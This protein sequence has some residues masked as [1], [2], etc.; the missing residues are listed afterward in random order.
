MLIETQT[1]AL[2]LLAVF[3]LFLS[4]GPNMAFVLSH[5][6]AHGARGGFAAALGITAADLVLTLLTVTGFTATV[7]AWPPAFDV[8]RYAG[9]LYLLVL[10][11]RAMRVPGSVQLTQR[12][13][14]SMGRI[15]CTAMLN[16][17]LNPKALLFFL[18]F[19]PQFVNPS[20]G[21]IGMQ[22]LVLGCTLSLAALLFNSLLGAFSGQVG[23]YLN[24]NHR[25]TRYQGLLLGGV[26]L[27][28]AVR[29]LLLERQPLVLTVPGAGAT[30]GGGNVATSLGTSMSHA[31][32]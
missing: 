7:A 22:L 18:V 11:Y 10:A 13:R 1:L 25:A 16:C 6:V 26:L 27:L 24:R 12:E 17:L 20:L 14:T 21:H 23:A 30:A 3:T 29:L 15:F 8:L 4:P 28:L 9:A 5:G 19:L 2:F 32:P 31:A